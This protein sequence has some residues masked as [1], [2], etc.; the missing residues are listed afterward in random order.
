[1]DLVSTWKVQR[2]KKEKKKKIL[3]INETKSW[4]FKKI[5]KID[6]T[7]AN[8]TKKKRERTQINKIRDERGNITTNTN[9]VQRLMREYSENL[10][11]NKL[12]N[13]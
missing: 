5:N 9:E 2:P 6:K 13:V 12:E 1:L 8:L 11:L 10:Y 4:C 7:L 3:Y